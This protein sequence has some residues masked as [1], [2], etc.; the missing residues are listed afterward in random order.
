MTT[1]IVYGIASDGYLISTASTNA[2]AASG[3][4]IAMTT[5]S[6]GAYFGTWYRAADGYRHHQGF[7][8]FTYPAVAATDMVTSASIRLSVTT[9]NSPAVTRRLEMRGYAYGTLATADWRT[10]AQLNAMPMQGEVM[11]VNTAANKF[12]YSGSG[13]L[14]STIPTVTAFEFVVVSDRQRAGTAPTVDESSVFYLSEGGG[15]TNDPQ[16]V[17]TSVARSMLVP[18]LGAQAKLSDGTWVCLK[19]TGTSTPAVTLNWINA[20][21][22]ETL[23]STLPMGTTNTT[24][25]YGDGA[26]NFAL[27]VDSSDNVYIFGKLGG[28]T[29]TVGMRAYAKNAGAGSWTIKN[30]YNS[31]MPAY[32]LGWLNQ[33]AVAW[34]NVSGGTLVIFAGHN[35]GTGISGGTGADITWMCVSSQ[36]LLTNGTG[37]LVRGSGNALGGVIPGITNGNFNSFANETGTGLDVV[38]ALGTT[39]PAWGY[40]ASFQKNVVLGGNGPVSLG[41]YIL[42]ATGTGFS[43]ASAADDCCAGTKD[44]NAKVRAV[45]IDSITTAVCATGADAG[46]GISIAVQRHSGTTAGSINLG[47]AELSG[48]SIATMPSASA[49]CQQNWWDVVYNASD[50][51]IW[52]YYVSASD[53]RVLMRTAFDLSSYNPVRNEVVVATIGSAGSTIQAVRVERYTSITGTCLVTVAYKTSGGSFNTTY[54]VDQ[55]ALA[56]N[57]PTLAV[58]P[59]FDATASSVFS[60]TF[61]DPNSGDTQTAYEMQVLDV[62]AGTN[63]I[64]T[65]TVASTT[66]SR[67]VTGGTLANNKNYQWRVR[68]TDTSGLV[69]PWSAY[70]TFQTGVGGSVTIT[71]PA[72]DNQGGVIS[73]S[74]RIA[75][76]VTGTTQA[77]YRVR[78]L[79]VSDNAVMSDSNWVASTATFFVT[80]AVMLS[81]VQYRAEVTV[82][83]AAAVESTTALRLILPSYASPPVPLPTVSPVP[84]QGYILVTADNP[85]PGSDAPGAATYGFESGVTNWIATGGTIAQSNLQ[86]HE[87]TYSAR[88]VTVGTVTQTY[89]RLNTAS[90]L[91]VLGG[92]RYKT[93]FW[94]YAPVAWNDIAIAIDWFTAAKAYIS[95]SAVGAPIVAGGWVYRSLVALAPANAAYAAFGPSVGTNPPNGTELF[96]DDVVM[97]PANDIPDA[98]INEVL[99]R[100]AGTNDRF[101]L[102][103]TFLPGEDFKDWTAAGGVTYEYRI[104]AVAA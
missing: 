48:E 96:F 45:A 34:H 46:D 50:N 30:L 64:A 15:T 82:R 78:I 20:A 39:N 63:T 7:F 23:V 84:E 40:V 28:T 100:V 52:A 79:R 89:A 80:P 87:G 17:F 66:P 75:W 33:L 60:W 21:G 57:A 67:T 36:Y 62:V 65:G 72:L 27:C 38:P 42:N 55:Y 12:V 29:N 68:T 93:E 101:T 103:G 92:G 2:A 99:R 43:H 22:T 37:T 97:V 5:G 95:T 9:T 14:A 49:I 98:A 59:N 77:A 32:Q 58:K 47:Y 54:V 85:T 16:M 90:L 71:D 74:V 91:P 41:R 26:Q 73:S 24:F 13:T 61:S 1:T 70:G 31:P 8:G 94:S 88:L 44:G 86:A 102:L 35:N 56:P 104:R 83:T 18:V 11:A 51:R 76:N 69:G 3:T 81:D 10:Q 53:P 6:T 19:S 4:A 25:D